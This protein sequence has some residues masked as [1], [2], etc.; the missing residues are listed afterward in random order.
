[1]SVKLY[2]AD[3]ITHLLTTIELCGVTVAQAVDAIL[4]QTKSAKVEVDKRG[5]KKRKT[6]RR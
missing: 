4:K 1:M 5:E 3:D 2:S 6:S